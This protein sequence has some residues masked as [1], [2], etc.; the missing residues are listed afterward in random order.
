ME[1]FVPD[2]LDEG[3]ATRQALERLAVKWRVLLIYAL[4]DGPQ[5]PARLRR[6][7]PGITP[8]M[9]TETLRGMQTDGLILRR[10]HKADPPQHVEYELTPLGRTLREPL[11]A[12]CAWARD[13]ST[14]APPPA[15]AGPAFTAPQPSAPP[16]DA[17]P[18]RVTRRAPVSRS[19]GS[20]GSR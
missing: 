18:T 16:Q 9:L 3:C 10:V 17:V 15:S 12:I 1:F 19:A 4:S 8:K 6:R 11:T 20:A 2:V 13:H 5:R 7:I 14:P